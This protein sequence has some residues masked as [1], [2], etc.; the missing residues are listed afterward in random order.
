MYHVQHAEYVRAED[1]YLF[2]ALLQ[3][4]DKHV[5]RGCVVAPHVV[6][7][8]GVVSQGRHVP[9][10]WCMVSASVHKVLH[11][12]AH[13]HL[14][15]GTKP[16]H[17]ANIYIMWRLASGS[18]HKILAHTH[19]HV[20]IKQSSTFI[21]IY[22]SLRA[23]GRHM[24]STSNFRAQ[25]KHDICILCTVSQ[26][27]KINGIC[28]ALCLLWRHGCCSH[29]HLFSQV[30]LLPNVVQQPGVVVQ[31]TDILR[32][33]FECKL[34]LLLHLGPRAATQQKELS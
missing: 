27:A 25:T 16:T 26:M 31:C 29:V 19:T 6:E 23:K 10:A 14:C 9:A 21:Y 2:R 15:V 18:T 34:Q 20:D 4:T 28:Q 17:T 24:K 32:I 33:R 5:L 22:M 30:S 1:V 11:M 7:K 13:T 8:E 12:R 3:S